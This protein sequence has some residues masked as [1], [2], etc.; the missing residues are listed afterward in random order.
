MAERFRAALTDLTVSGATTKTVIDTPQR[1]LWRRFPPQVPQVPADV[2]LVTITAGGN[3]LSYLATMLTQAYAGL[4]A[5]HRLTR[6]L[7]SRMARGGVAR[8]AVEDVDRAAQGLV[9]IV[10][11]VGRRAPSARIILVDYLTILG[12]AT[13]RGREAPFD[14]RIRD[15]LRELGEEVARAFCVAAER[16]GAE[17]VAVG[18]LSRGHVVGSAEPW[19]QGFTVGSAGAFH[20]NVAG[21]R[22]VSD[23]I[24]DHL[25]AAL[26]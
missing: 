11:A 25:H 19:V 13:P 16:S 15:S 12:P 3:D 24:V 6:P 9:D 20:P 23:A 14:G 8:P 10:A 4:L 5:D 2:D 18:E 7:G 1:L 17:L 22:A 26:R 21:M